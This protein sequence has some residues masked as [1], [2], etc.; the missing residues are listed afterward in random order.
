MNSK[1]AIFIEYLWIAIAGTALVIGIYE[2]Y[3][4]DINNASMFFAIVFISV[5]MY[6]FRRK[7]RIKRNKNDE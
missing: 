5:L 3:T 2:W 4:R 7:M 6:S 1:F